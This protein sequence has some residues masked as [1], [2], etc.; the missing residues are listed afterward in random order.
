MIYQSHIILV[1]LDPFSNE[2][3][4]E[5]HFSETSLPILWLVFKI[6]QGNCGFLI[7]L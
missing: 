7:T 2:D 5:N 1:T 6:Q 3:L 4:Y